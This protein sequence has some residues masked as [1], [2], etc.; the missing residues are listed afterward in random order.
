MVF[1][2]Q[3]TVSTRGHGDM[4][5]LTAQ[6]AAV[7]ARSKVRTGLVHVFNVGSTAA[8]GIIEFEPGLQQDLPAVARPPHA[9][10]PRLRPRADLARRQ[11][12]L[13]PSGDRCSGQGL[14]V[15]VGDGQAPARHLA[16]DLPPGVRHPPARTHGRGDRHGRIT[17]DV[18]ASL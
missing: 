14:T 16:A 2:E 4:H 18:A 12:P 7:V 9:A 3:L 6:V 15:P 10:Q 8:V 1:Q 13:A 11:R 17:I 5:D